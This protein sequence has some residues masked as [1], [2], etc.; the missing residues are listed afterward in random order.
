M[1]WLKGVI[2]DWTVV[3]RKFYTIVENT[4]GMTNRIY[5]KHDKQCYDI[6]EAKYEFNKMYGCSDLLLIENYER[7]G[8]LGKGKIVPIDRKSIIGTKDCD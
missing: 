6:N 2:C 7:V 3:T 1:D 8:C 4:N 5:P